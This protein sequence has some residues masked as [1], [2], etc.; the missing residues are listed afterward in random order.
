M[1]DEEA[2]RWAGDDEPALP[3]AA[4]RSGRKRAALGTGNAGLIALGALGGVA[5]IETL[6][7]FSYAVRSAYRSTDQLAAAMFN[8]GLWL[9]VAAPALWLGLW[10]WRLPAGRWRHLVLIAGAI[11]LL[12]YPVLVGR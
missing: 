2:L 5:L 12:P 3:A 6:A 10:L 11:A 7:W 8:L 9:A 1:S 4:A